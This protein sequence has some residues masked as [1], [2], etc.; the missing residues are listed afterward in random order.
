M[1]K[2]YSIAE[3]RN[4]LAK[5]VR[6]AETGQEV[7]LTRRGKSVAVLVGRGDYERL[8][9]GP[10]SFWGAYRAFRRAVDLADLAI[11]PEVIF[12][13]ARDRSLGRN[14]SL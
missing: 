7:A 5:I 1:S 9:S 4:N 14:V 11:D 10:K 2:K 12:G 3:A 13:S 8:V 6:E